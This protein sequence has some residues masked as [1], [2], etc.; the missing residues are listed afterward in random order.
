M[1]ESPTFHTR[2]DPWLRRK[3]L[4]VKYQ[5]VL[6]FEDKPQLRPIQVLFYEKPGVYK[7]N[8]DLQCLFYG[9]N[10]SWM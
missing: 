10:K 4:R 2:I 8:K 6:L 9:H 3:E 1:F 7:G 5:H